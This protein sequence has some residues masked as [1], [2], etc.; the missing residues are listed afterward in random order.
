MPMASLI[1]ALFTKPSIL[2]SLARISFTAYSQSLSSQRLYEAEIARLLRVPLVLRLRE[3]SLATPSTLVFLIDNLSG[4][5]RLIVKILDYGK[6]KYE[7][8]K[9]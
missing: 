8:K 9:K 5:L 2:L 4:I 7:R 1:P 3:E 6:F